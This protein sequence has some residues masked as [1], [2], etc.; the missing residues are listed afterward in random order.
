MTVGV[1]DLVVVRHG[2]AV[3]VM[4][5]AR[6]DEMRRVVETLESERRYRTYL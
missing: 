4:D 1:K 5:R 6:E 3:L 2:D